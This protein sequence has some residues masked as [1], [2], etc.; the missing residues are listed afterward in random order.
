MDM[1]K[2]YD[3][4]CQKDDVFNISFAHAHRL[5][6][7]SRLNKLSAAIHTYQREVDKI[8]DSIDPLM[9]TVTSEIA[10][11]LRDLT[12]LL[13]V[14]LWPKINKLKSDCQQLL[15]HLLIF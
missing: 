15:F 11:L 2:L 6:E 9:N 10:D 3:I 1:V 8:P 14:A 12:T 5:Y 4:S 7:Q 13:P